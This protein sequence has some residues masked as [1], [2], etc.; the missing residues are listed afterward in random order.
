MV[1]APIGNA[2]L[3]SVE[4]S[5]GVVPKPP[6]GLPR[7]DSPSRSELTAGTD[8]HDATRGR[9]IANPD[10]VSVLTPLEAEGVV[11]GITLLQFDDQLRMRSSLRA[12]RAT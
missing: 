6:T 4:R 3:L 9:A 1:G 11:H 7:P 8:S 12:R 10:P 2:Y 5:R